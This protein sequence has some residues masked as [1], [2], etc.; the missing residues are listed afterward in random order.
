LILKK[1]ENKAAMET[2]KAKIKDA[3]KKASE[4]D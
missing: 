3:K 4:Y 2:V 1:E